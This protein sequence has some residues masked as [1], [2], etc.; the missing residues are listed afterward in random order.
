MTDL[1]RKIGKYE[2]VQEVGRGSMG[3]VYSAHDPFS[4]RLVAVKL[5]HPQHT[6]N[7]EAGQ[8]FRKLFF[9]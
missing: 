9:N 5:A 7:S 2:V 3:A 6:D 1:P 8:R 4:D